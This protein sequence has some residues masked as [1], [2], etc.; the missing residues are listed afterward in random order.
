MPGHP[1]ARGPGA[2]LGAWNGAGLPFGHVRLPG[3]RGCASRNGAL[4]RGV[5]RQEIAEP[6]GADFYIGL[7]A[8]EDA[9]VADLIPP[10]GPPDRHISVDVMH[11]RTREWRGSEI[12][13]IGGTGNARAIAEI[14]AI[15]ANGGVARASAFS[16]KRDVAGRWKFRCRGAIAFSDSRSATGW[17]SRSP[18]ACLL[19][20][21]RGRSI[22]EG[23]EDRLRS[24]TWMLAPPLRTP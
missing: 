13:A 2:R 6:M 19:F 7:P 21:T 14:H 10:P 23:M 4:V 15:L 17:G 12:P 3:R 9:R 5:F 8:L 22:R 18:A 11:T 1:V 24:S 20:P 16:P